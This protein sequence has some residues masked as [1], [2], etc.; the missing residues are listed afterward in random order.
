MI[1]AFVIVLREAL[2]AALVV[3]VVLGATKG[4]KGR[5]SWI[6]W[7]IAAGVLG[8]AVVA[9]LM[10][11]LSQSLSG[12]G[13]PIFEAAVLL[14]A[15]AMLG[16]H[17]VW[18][19]RHGRRIS[20]ELKSLGREVGAG[21]KTMA[22]LF[23]VTAVAVLR[24]GSEVVLFLYGVAASGAGAAS[25]LLG[26]LLGLAA[27]VLVGAALYQGLLRIPVRHFFRVTGWLILL[28][29][30]GMA[31][32]A[33]AF[34]NQADLLPALGNSLWNTSWLLSG[35]GFLGEAL[36][37]LVG[38]TPQPSGIQLFF[39]AATLLLIG[40]L[41]RLLREERA[42]EPERVAEQ[43]QAARGRPQ[44]AAAGGLRVFLAAL[45]LAG[46]A[47]P[48]RAQRADL[49]SEELKVYSPAVSKGERELEY[50][51]FATPEGQQGLAFS[52]SYSPT[53]Y[54]ESEAYE[55][56][57]RSPAQALVGKNVTLEQRFQLSEPGERWLD[58]GLIVEA[59]IPE[60]RN[61]PFEEE[62]VPILEKQFDSI[63]VTLNPGLEWQSG[64]GY[65][66]GTDFHYAASLKYLLNPFFSP[67]AEFFG[68]PGVIG[69]FPIADRQTHLTGPAV[70]GSWHQG[71]RRDLRYSAALLFGLNSQTP[72]RALVTRLEFEF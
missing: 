56:F 32:Q 65:A 70:Y 19:S 30:A 40:G 18:M 60:R 21:R 12:A 59:A 72:V 71:P 24:E 22:A 10:G 50:R 68:E 53:P 46:A 27:G 61:E 4:L 34:L 43:E 28:L 58:A 45:I 44:G 37:T 26:G 16:W 20:R 41:T 42:P 9:S 7:G 49:N 63:V 51:G 5:W 55:V 15:V 6:G 38:Y 52:A 67:G 33:A 17:N 11:R 29:A 23:F 2:E 39:Y 69:S 64:P 8:A 31:S 66:P 13:E 14:S 3:A 54:W 57:H 36:K 25:L 35:G 1:A 48:A 47:A 62:L